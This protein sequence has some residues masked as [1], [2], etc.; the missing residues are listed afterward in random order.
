MIGPLKVKSLGAAMVIV[1]LW[2]SERKWFLAVSGRTEEIPNTPQF[3]VVIVVIRTQI[4]RCRIIA[5]SI[6]SAALTGRGKVFTPIRR[7][8]KLHLLCAS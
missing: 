4:N 3:D 7:V 1:G 5:N 6:Q 8:Y 2:C